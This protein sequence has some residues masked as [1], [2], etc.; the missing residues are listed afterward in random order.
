[1]RLDVLQIPKPWGYEGWYTGVEIRGVALIHD[2]FGRTE[3]PY[4]LGLFPEPLLN[5]ADEQ[6]ILLK[7]L[8]PVREEVLG[9]LYLEMHEKKWEA[10]SY[11][12][13]TLPTKA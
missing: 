9:D 4:A 10:V 3:L 13:L 2:R 5:G 6:L 1:M 7:T 11:T 12:H 8:N